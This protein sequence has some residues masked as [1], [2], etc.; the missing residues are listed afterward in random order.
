MGTDEH[1]RL[2]S[3]D[4]WLICMANLML[5]VSLYML[6]PVLPAWMAVSCGATLEEA[7]GIMA[8]FGVAAFAV[9]PV[10]SYLADT[11]RRKGLCLLAILAV[12]AAVGGF[13]FA[14]GL[15]AAA[16]LRV[17]QGMMYGMALMASGSTLVIDISK[18]PRRTDAN[19]AFSWFGRF[20]FSL[21]P[22]AGLLLYE[23]GSFEVVLAVSCLLGLLSFLCVAGV[24]VPFRAPLCP[25]V[26]SKDR[27]WL[28][29][30]WL[31]FV[32][33]LWV[34]VPTGILLAVVRSY[35][36][37]GVLMAGFC[38]AVLAVRFVFAEA[39]MRSEVVSGLLLY[40]CGLLLLMARQGEAAFYASALFVGLGIGLTASRM[41]YF[42]IKLSEHCE[43][44]TA[45]TSA[46]LGWELGISAG[47]FV[48]C[49]LSGCVSSSLLY[50]LALGSLA[51]ALILYLAVIHP[52]YLRHKVR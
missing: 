43:R 7:G 34:S 32:N 6:W 12:A 22:M 40:G 26:F 18:S 30:G 11:Y 25:P 3:R 27:F 47:F 44:G 39:D 10:F 17:L 16:V 29:N 49:L 45:N 1:T 46:A 5:S 48:G 41:L 24:R 52:W 42:F 37:Y 23:L 14:G 33:L 35:A 8:L 4:F 38:F 31:M 15:L 20:G 28:S 9:G 19:N 36:F 2:W 21:G 51:I 13:Y 50:G